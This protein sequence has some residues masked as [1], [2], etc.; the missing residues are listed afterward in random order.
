MKYV[1]LAVFALL[2]IAVLALFF[3][4]KDY[5]DVVHEKNVR[6]ERLSKDLTKSEVSNQE[7]DE[8]IVEL[9]DSVDS[10]QKNV[11]T[12]EDKLNK[13]AIAKDKLK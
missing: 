11:A 9:H 3:K 2:S 1:R 6:I 5:Q 4:I 12:L 7:K 10:L 13:L 8:Y